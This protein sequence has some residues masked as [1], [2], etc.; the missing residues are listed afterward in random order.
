M[1]IVETIVI[2]FG[3]SAD[4][5]A[6]SLANGM[7]APRIGWRD[8]LKTGLFFGGFQFLMTVIGYFLGLLVADAIKQVDH[9]IAF[10]LLVLIGMQMILETRK[11]ESSRADC[12][13]TPRLFVSAIATSIDALATGVSL[14]ILATPILPVATTIGVTTCMLSIPGV[15]LGKRLGGFLQKGAAILGGVLLMLIGT[16]ILLE[17]LGILSL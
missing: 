17:H 12:M 4:A 16:A 8:A 14:A 13:Q 10:G 1:G 9:W 6:V 2:S 3:L 11:E 15:F 7:A 5:C